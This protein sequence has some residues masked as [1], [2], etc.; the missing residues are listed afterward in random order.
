MRERKM[1][2]VFQPSDGPTLTLHLRPH[3][4]NDPAADDVYLCGTCGMILARG[5]SLDALEYVAVE[6]RNCGTCN[7]P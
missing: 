6:C 3:P 1:H 5:I 2:P 7:T 4:E